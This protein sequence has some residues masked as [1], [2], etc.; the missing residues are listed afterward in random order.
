MS[1]IEQQIRDASA[2]N[3][4]LLRTLAETDYAQPSLKEQIILIDDLQKQI[5]KN[6]KNLQF[7][8]SQ[9]KAELKDHEKYRD[10]HFRR[11]LYKA[12]GNKDKFAEKASK[13]EKEYYDVLQKQ[14]ETTVLNNGLKEQHEEAKRVRGELETAVELHNHSQ[15]ELD[16]LYNSIFA[17]ETPRFPEEDALERES[18]NSLQRYHDVRT[19]LEEEMRVMKLVNQAQ[20]KVKEALRHMDDARS[21]SRM[22]MFGFD[23]IADA[24]ERSALTKAD[25]AYHDARNF[26]ER[27]NFDDLPAVNINHG[28]IMRDVIFDNIFT[29]MQFHEEIKRAQSEMEKFGNFIKQK[30]TISQDRKKGIEVELKQAEKDLE[31]ARINLQ[32]ERMKLFEQVAKSAP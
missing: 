20:G 23:G 6:S 9:R 18:D 21:A 27:A 13:E 15:L 19:K 14:H 16:S 28:H 1:S 26:A 30:L 11:F 29:D 12:T 24:M 25:I 2:R 32:E 5:E 4:E 7:Y 22:D 3:A 17:G 8:D 31:T 10:S